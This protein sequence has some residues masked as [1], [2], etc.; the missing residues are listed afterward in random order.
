MALSSVEL[1]TRKVRVMVLP[2]TPWAVAPPLSP[3]KAG[4]QF[5]EWPVQV[6]CR[7]PGPHLAP[8]LAKP[9]AAAVPAGPA[10]PAPFVAP[11]VVAAAVPV[12]EAVP[13]DGDA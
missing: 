12:L 13:V 4:V 9:D 5:G 3:L 1:G 6:N 8:V 11:G 7:T 2:V 10:A